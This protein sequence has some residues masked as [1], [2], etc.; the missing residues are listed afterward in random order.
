VNSTKKEYI[1]R[2][3]YRTWVKS[4]DLSFFEV[5]YFKTDL[6]VGVDRN[7]NIENISEISEDRVKDCVHILQAYIKKRNEFGRSLKPIK[8][9]Y[10]TDAIITDMIKAAQLCS[11][12]PMA[13][14]AGEIADLVGIELSKFSSNVIVENGGDIFIKINRNLKIGIFAGKSLFTGKIFVE[15]PPTNGLGVCT[16][17]GTVGPSLSFGKADAAVIIGKTAC[18]ADAAATAV[19]NLV[20]KESDFTKAINF[21]KKIKGIEGILI[22]MNDKMAVWGNVNLSTK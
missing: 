14:V 7:A 2:S 4:E 13:A 3:L 9:T 1:N 20:K 15:I 17:S 12:G 18:L 22:V 8:P 19:G 5:K 21:G 10:G 16:S 6:L 11:V